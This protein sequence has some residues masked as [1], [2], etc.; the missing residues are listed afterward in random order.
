MITMRQDDILSHIQDLDTDR[1]MRSAASGGGRI[2]LNALFG[3]FLYVLV[4]K[5]TSSA[6]PEYKKQLC[7][8]AKQIAE[9]EYCVNEV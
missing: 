7:F 2:I 6:E 5:V 1:H 8:S 3:S 4:V 9:F